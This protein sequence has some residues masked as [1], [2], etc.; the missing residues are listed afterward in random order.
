MSIRTML[1][2][3]VMA[4]FLIVSHL[5]LAKRELVLQAFS[6]EESKPHLEIADAAGHKFGK[7]AKTKDLNLL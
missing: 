2:I 7:V 4:G 1:S 6:D 5:L 3:V